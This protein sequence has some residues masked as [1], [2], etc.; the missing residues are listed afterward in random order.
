M[1]L[2]QGL[3]EGI[4]RLKAAGI[5]GAA[6]D[7][8]ALLAEAAG[9]APGR[10]MLEADMVLP[11]PARF[12]ALIA[13][14]AAGEPVSRILGRRQ[15]WGRD[16][17][18]TRDTLD[19]RPETET[20]IAAALDIGPVARFADLGTGTGIIAVSLLGEWPGATA[21]ATDISGPALAVAG[22]NASDQGVRGRLE[23]LH[24]GK[25]GV[26]LPEEIGRFDLILSNPPYISAR[27]MHDLAREVRDHDPHEALT[28]GGDGLAPY[29]AIAAQAARHLNAGGHVMVE[30]GW[31][32]GADV[33][34]L[35]RAAG[36]GKL[37]VLNDLDGRDRVVAAQ[38]Q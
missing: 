18:V 6:R 37:R 15:F 5:D 10:V 16:F 29:R 20:L 25:P 13:R 36:L 31:R 30:I 21:L 12:R 26:W 19:P 23:L 27:E 32:Q 3:A 1:N 8:R 7:A 9:I 17:T 38:K 2:R 4:A 22:M 34:A 33:A 28:P 24:I 14:R 35:F 11:D